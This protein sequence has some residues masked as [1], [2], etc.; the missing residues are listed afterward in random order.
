MS[1]CEVLV[2]QQNCNLLI[3][4]WTPQL[5]RQALRRYPEYRATADRIRAL[6]YDGDKILGGTPDP[7]RVTHVLCDLDQAISHVWTLDHN[8]RRARLIHE[9]YRLGRET[10]D[11]ADN[12]GISQ[13]WTHQLISEG[14]MD[15]AKFLGWRPD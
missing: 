8:H 11:V 7:W 5:V 1:A 6:S 15:I 14:I 4:D 13:R 9:H 12:H 2:E 10:A 3:I